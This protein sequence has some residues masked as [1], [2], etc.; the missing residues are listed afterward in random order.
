MGTSATTAASTAHA[1]NL[2]EFL[3]TS[4]ISSISEG[5][6]HILDLL[7]EVLHHHVVLSRSQLLLGLSLVA[8]QDGLSL[9]NVT[10]TSHLGSLLHGILIQQLSIC[11]PVKLSTLT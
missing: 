5:S 9:A 4:A 11:I 3:L 7:R 2:V 10:S 1:H 8:L 6:I